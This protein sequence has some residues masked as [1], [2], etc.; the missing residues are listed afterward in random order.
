[1]QGEWSPSQQ[2]TKFEA[3]VL[4]QTYQ[5]P[6]ERQLG[7]KKRGCETLDVDMAADIQDK[8]DQLDIERLRFGR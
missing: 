6:P 8:K 4:G 2:P 3:E 7:S 1:L 5:W